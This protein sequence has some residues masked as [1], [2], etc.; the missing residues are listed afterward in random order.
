[1]IDFFTNYLLTPYTQ[2][3]L[4][5]L[6]VGLFFLQQRRSALMVKTLSWVRTIVLLLMFLYFAWNWASEIPPSLRTA[7]VLGMFLINLSMIYNLLLGKLEENYHQA[8]E[9]CA[10]AA[11]D[12]QRLETVWR[13]GRTF[14]NTRFFFEALVSGQSPRIFLQGVINH[15]IPSDIQRVLSK[16]GQP[17][18]ILTHATLLTFLG[19]RL[20]QSTLLP[21]ELKEAI[22]QSVKQF[23]EHAWINEQV[24]DFLKK[25][26][27]D[28]ESLTELQG[29]PPPPEG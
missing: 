9:A 16:H 24:D 29:P 1:M 7:S 19:N 26:L 27:T 11:G 17:A 15:Q 28:P 10:L 4:F 22:G 20:A 21:P 8:L 23:A 3:V 18:A 2:A 25:A 5:F 14:L 13:T 6:L 12:K